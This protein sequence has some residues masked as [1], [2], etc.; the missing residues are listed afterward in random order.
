MATTRKR[1]LGRKRKGKDFSVLPSRKKGGN[2]I[3]QGKKKKAVVLSRD[4]G[5]KIRDFKMG[6]GG[7][8]IFWLGSVGIDLS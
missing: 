1:F 8:Y 4:P 2:F 5:L 3:F 6:R 7:Q